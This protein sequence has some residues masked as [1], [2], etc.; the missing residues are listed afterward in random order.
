LDTCRIRGRER[1]VEKFQSYT[2]G[3]EPAVPIRSPKRR[4]ETE[5]GEGNRAK[6]RRKTDSASK[7]LELPVGNTTKPAKQLCTFEKNK[8]R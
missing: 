8:K 2:K 7:R 1:G 3:E 6:E 4:R 5:L